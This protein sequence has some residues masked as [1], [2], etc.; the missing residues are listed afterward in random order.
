MRSSNGAILEELF[1]VEQ[2]AAILQ[3]TP[4]TIKD[5]LRAGKLA[6]YKMGRLWRVREADLEALIQAS[7]VLCAREE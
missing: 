6:G 7:R 2:A 3:L 5:W 1:T 4:K